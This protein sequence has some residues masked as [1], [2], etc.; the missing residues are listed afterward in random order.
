VRVVV[1]DEHGVE[2]ARESGTLLVCLVESV[3][4]G[5]AV[6]LAFA[7]GVATLAVPAGR[8]LVFGRLIAR[9]RETVALNELV[10][11]EPGDEPLVVRGRWLP[12]GSLRV[13]DA[14]TQQDLGGV[15]VRHADGWRA[16][17]SWSH[18]GDHP[19]V[20]SAVTGGASP[21]TLPDRTWFTPYWVHAPEHAWT[22][23]D[24]DH[25]TG[26]TRTVELAR[27]RGVVELTCTG[28][29]PPETHARLYGPGNTARPVL[30]L[31]SYSA[32]VSV[33]L[34]AAG[35][36]R[37]EDLAPGRYVAVLETGEYEE[38]VHL[39]PPVELELVA[40][41][42]ARVALALNPA[43]LAPTTTH[44]LG[45]L[46]VPS[47]LLG[48]RHQMRLERLDRGQADVLLPLGQMDASED[49]ETLLL[50][51][52]GEVRTGTFLANLP[53]QY[54]VRLE[55]GVAGGET[56]VALAMPPVGT[57]TVEVIDAASGAPLVPKRLSWAVGAL[58]GISHSTRSS[59]DERA[60][61]GTWRFRAPRGRIDVSASQPGYMDADETLELAVPE[62]RVR[63]ALR[64]A[65]GVRILPRDGDSAVTPDHAWFYQVRL[66]A[67]DG[68]PLP[69]LLSIAGEL[70]SRSVREPGTYTLSFPPLEGF[71]PIPE[72]TVEI[73]RDEV[74]DVIVPLERD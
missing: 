47:E 60:A 63:L 17:P 6:E 35:P 51:D 49:D 10:P 73:G 37:I 67:A 9:G 46:R 25:A 50:W 8:K 24:F 21:V 68:T 44:L 56:R 22:R 65:M 1:V 62:A 26:G 34:A 15:E 4:K 53:L 42:T 66:R 29:P 52:A 2:Y 36:T 19:S 57:V 70:G 55:A 3:G 23:V 18:P 59:M 12:R 7:D 71:R 39:G 45:T 54:R 69:D 5:D 27:E 14:D 32:A 48:G 33:R 16:N 72:R 20:V 40:G 38:R 61:D 13:I 30:E 43:A 28:T 64:R 58:A 41:D 74:V 11:V 31:P